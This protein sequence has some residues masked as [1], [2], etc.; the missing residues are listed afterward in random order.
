MC[1]P[2]K[3]QPQ[4]ALGINLFDNANDNTGVS[5]HLLPHFRWFSRRAL[6]LDDDQLD[7]NEAAAVVTQKLFDGGARRAEV[8]RQASRVDGA[9]FRVLER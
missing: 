8:D 2:R 3:L 4:P 7:P 1:E 9:S 6:N 5:L